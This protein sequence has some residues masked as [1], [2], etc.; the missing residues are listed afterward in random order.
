MI[1]L[2]FVVALMPVLGLSA[3]CAGAI[4]LLFRHPGG[5][6]GAGGASSGS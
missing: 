1:G 5:G 6:T 4:W 2:G 3:L